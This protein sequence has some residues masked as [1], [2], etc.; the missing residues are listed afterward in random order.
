[1]QPWSLCSTVLSVVWTAVHVHGA[2]CSNGTSPKVTWTQVGQTVSHSD[3]VAITMTTSPVNG[4]PLFAYGFED[5]DRG[6]RVRVMDWDGE[7]WQI[8]FDRRSQ[9]PQNYS[10]FDIKVRRFSACAHEKNSRFHARAG[11]SRP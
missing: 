3:V 5:P 11:R 9:F 4:L 8:G 10:E 6:T 1:M 2:P 7:A